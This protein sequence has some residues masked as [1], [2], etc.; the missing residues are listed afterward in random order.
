MKS[1]NDKLLSW[2]APSHLKIIWANASD[3]YTSIKFVKPI[4]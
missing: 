3:I 4:N 2:H 1:A